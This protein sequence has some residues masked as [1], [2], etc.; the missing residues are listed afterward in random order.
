MIQDISFEFN[1]FLY[2]AISFDKKN[3]SLKV[4]KCDKYGKVL[5]KTELKMAIIPKSVKK[6]LNPLK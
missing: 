4:N 5:E 3:N 2:K 1:G 6:K